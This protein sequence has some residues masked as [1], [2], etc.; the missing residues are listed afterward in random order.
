MS[1]VLRVLWRSGFVFVCKK[2]SVCFLEDLLFFSALGFSFFYCHLESTKTRI[3]RFVFFIE[4]FLYLLDKYCWT[5]LK[6]CQTKHKKHA[7]TVRQFTNLLNCRTKH[8][9]Y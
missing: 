5:I 8:K 4:H 7:E 9:I 6:N 1:S 2:L 3:S